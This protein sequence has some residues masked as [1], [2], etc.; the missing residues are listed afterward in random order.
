[1]EYEIK[2]SGTPFDD[3]AID[4]DR[5]EFIAQYLRDIAKGAL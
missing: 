3:G 5:L 4:L 2:L 1:M